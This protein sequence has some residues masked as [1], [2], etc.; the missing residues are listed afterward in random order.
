M[1]NV[2]LRPIEL[3]D[4]E[5]IV[6]WRNQKSVRENLFSRELIT[7]AQHITYFEKY[8]ASNKVYQFIISSSFARGG[9][10]LI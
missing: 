6:K 3:S 4:T 9:Y 10:C 8:I 7:P 5:N 1:M 2:S